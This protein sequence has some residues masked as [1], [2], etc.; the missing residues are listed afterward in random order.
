[1]RQMTPLTND[2]AYT[3]RGHGDYCGRCLRDRQAPLWDLAPM[4][5]ARGV[6][7]RSCG[8][9]LRSSHGGD[10]SGLARIWALA[11]ADQAL[12]VRPNMNQHREGY[13]F[14]PAHAALRDPRGRRA[15]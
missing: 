4:R 12:S 1:M 8:T 5:G 3:W 7:C 2:H 13:G 9:V 15:A 6:P 10:Q 11:G 14:P